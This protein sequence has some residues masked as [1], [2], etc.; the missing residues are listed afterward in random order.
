MRYAIV[1]GQRSEASRG[2]LGTCP[3]CEVALRPRC[4]RFRQ[5]HWAHPPGIVD[6][7]WEPETEWHRQWKGCFPEDCQEVIHRAD[8]GERHI[9]DVKT[10]HG[11]VIELQNS[12]ISEEERS[13]R[14]AFYRPMLWVVNGQRLKSD[15]TKFYA[16]LRHGKIVKA[17]PLTVLVPR[18]E[19]LLLRKWEN[20]GTLV[21]FDFGEL[22]EASEAP[23]FGAPVLWASLPSK[24]E[25]MAVIMPIFRKSFLDAVVS[26]GPLVG[27][28]CGANVQPVV[29]VPMPPSIQNWQPRLGGGSRYYQR[30]RN[31]RM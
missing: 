25:G 11:Q 29:R 22:E 9:A 6:H 12:P 23:R 10:A 4:G 24:Q 18:Q 3:I 14:E 2:L 27:I 5:A 8:N 16:S 26:G 19:C 1:D 20:S 28:N 31:W 17:N 30:R 13:S 21:L 7:R 15:A